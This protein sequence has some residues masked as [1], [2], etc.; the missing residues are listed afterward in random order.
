M[1]SAIALSRYSLMWLYV[2]FDLP[3]LTKANR[4]AAARFRKD[5]IRDGFTMM[6][7][8][9]YVRHCASSE[10]AAVHISRIKNFVP[11]QGLV[12]IVKITD[13]QFGETVHYVG[14]K[15]KP[16]PKTPAQLELF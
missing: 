7:W 11:A 5:L 1:P 8:S 13:R 16:P 14:R 15:E 12:S 4:K 2:F 6:Q 9:V 10:S 3:T